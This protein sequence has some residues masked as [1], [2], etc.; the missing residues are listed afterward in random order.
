MATKRKEIARLLLEGMSQRDICC[1]MH[2]SKRDVSAVAKMVKATGIS[3]EA[4][5]ELTEQDVRQLLSPTKQREEPY[6]QP[7]LERI[8]SELKRPGVTR[9][10][11]WY[12]YGN[13]TLGDGQ[14]LYSYQQ[15]CKLVDRHLLITK[16]TMHLTH[17]PGRVLYVDWAGDTLSV[18]DRVTGADNT[19]YL[20]VACLPYS[21]NFYVEGFLDTK[22]RSWLVGHMDAFEHFGGVPAMLVPDNCATAV[23]RTPI[24]LTVINSTYYDFAEHYQSAVVPTRSRRPRDKAMVE[25]AVGLVERWICAPLRDQVFFSLADLNEVIWDKADKLCAQPYQVRPG[26]RDSVFY[27]EEKEFLKPLAPSRFEI[28]EWKTAKV[29]HDY[30][31][32]ADY[33]RY[34]VPYAL[35]GQRLDVRLTTGKVEVFKDGELVASHYRKFG[36]KGQCGTLPEHMPPNHRYYLSSYSPERFRRWAEA[37]GPA[38]TRIIDGVLASRAII[39]QAF[40][41]CAN[42]LGL[43]K[44]GGSELLEAASARFLEYGTVAT[45]TQLKHQMEAIKKSRETLPVPD[46][47]DIDE[48]D[49]DDTTGRTRGAGYYRR[50]K[51]GF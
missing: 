1:A 48:P 20:F 33:M 49:G 23:D 15:F 29:A 26:S 44:K 38:C 2:C 5:A 50:Q 51:G 27:E 25:A 34:S 42:I 6:V 45:Y 30:H 3:K 32:Q 28:A 36:R 9:K 18:R 35:I 17:E 12:E 39:E 40:V 41:P 21:G 31:V 19:V 7:D 16:A 47:G 37:I 10:L 24:Y 22:Q 11:L 8:A 4:L 43:S 14:K 46:D 13:T